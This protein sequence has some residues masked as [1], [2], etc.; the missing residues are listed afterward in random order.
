MRVALMALLVIPLVFGCGDDGDK[1]GDTTGSQA[2]ADADA[3]ADPIC[4]DLEEAT[5]EMALEG[6]IEFGWD[7]G[8]G[9]LVCSDLDEGET[10]PDYT[11]I[12]SDFIEDNIGNPWGDI[13]CWYWAT[14]S[15]GPE[16]S[17]PDRC[18]YAF[19]EWAMVCS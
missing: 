6:T 12:D 9:Y 15:C 3:D 7:A 16:T 13:Y 19:V 11:E 17:M 1:S 14:P 18:C 4:G 5:S 2:D 10:C 8:E